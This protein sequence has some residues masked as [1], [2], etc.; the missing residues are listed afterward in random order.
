M[1][2]IVVGMVLLWGLVAASL[3]ARRVVEA[4]RDRTHALIAL[5]VRVLPPER[6]DWGQAML[7]ELDPIEGRSDRWR[8]ALGCAQTALLTPRRRKPVSVG[9]AA[10]IVVG[11]A[12][13]GLGISAASPFLRPLFGYAMG[14]RLII[15]AMIGAVAAWTSGRTRT[16]IGAGV[17]AGLIGGL[18]L[19]VFGMSSTLAM[20]NGFVP[21]DAVTIGSFQTSGLP[22]VATYEVSDNLGGFI[23]ALWM[24]PAHSVAF[25]VVGAAL[26]SNASRF[27]RRR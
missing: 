22:D 9:L 25:S 6:H 10:T 14:A 26:G 5:V 3:A 23:M 15:P 21:V 7:A 19:F 18:L 17:W 12:C 27:L 8:F 2:I 16:G 11:S 24:L 20:A 13:V 4:G 1:L